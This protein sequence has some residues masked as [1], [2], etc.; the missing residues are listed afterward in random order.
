MICW[1]ASGPKCPVDQEHEFVATAPRY[2]IA[3]PHTG[4]QARGDFFQQFVADVVPQ[5]V[6]DV[7]ETIEIDKGD[8]ESRA[9]TARGQQG[10]LQAVVQQ[11]NGWQVR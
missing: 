4:Q 10:L 5:A 9:E 7:L 11:P 1:T 8:R 3:L 6:V 2:R